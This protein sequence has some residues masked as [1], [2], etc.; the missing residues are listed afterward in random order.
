MNKFDIDCERNSRALKS[1]LQNPG[2]NE[3]NERKRPMDIRMEAAQI[4]PI[5]SRLMQNELMA[6]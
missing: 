5:G 2:D 1:R 4:G 6:V 3:G